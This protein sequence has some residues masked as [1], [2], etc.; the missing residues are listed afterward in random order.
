MEN[1]NPYVF[2]SKKMR[3]T[4]TRDK[5]KISLNSRPP[6][7]A[8][9]KILSDLFTLN[10]I[11]NNPIAKFIIERI[12]PNKIDLKIN[13]DILDKRKNIVTMKSVRKENTLQNTKSCCSFFII[14]G[15]Q[16]RFNESIHTGKYTKKC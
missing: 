10:F 1:I 4:N 6:Q 9:K 3:V 14:S 12:A 2:I 11:S 5:P 16:N 13:A 15:F 7:S 8:S